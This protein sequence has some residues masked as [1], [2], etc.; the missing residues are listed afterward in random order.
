MKLPKYNSCRLRQFFF[1]Q[2]YILCLCVCVYLCACVCM[3]AGLQPTVN[4][5]TMLEPCRTVSGPSASTRTTAKHMAGWGKTL[6]CPHTHL[7]IC[8]PFNTYTCPPTHVTLR[9]CETWRP[10]VRDL[11]GS[12][13]CC[14]SVPA[15][16]WRA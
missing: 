10:P 4:W 16:L 5:G 15:W 7:S 14:V 13:W 6:V 2:S 8:T 9:H 1:S 11:L 3:C 12:E